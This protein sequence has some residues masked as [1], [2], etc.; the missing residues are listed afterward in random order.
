MPFV[1]STKLD[2]FSNKTQFLSPPVTPKQI[3]ESSFHTNRQTEEYCWDSTSTEASSSPSSSSL[4]YSPNISDNC[5]QMRKKSAGSINIMFT[6]IPPYRR[7]QR[8]IQSLPTST[9]GTFRMPTFVDTV[10]NKKLRKRAK[11][12]KT[13]RNS[14][15]CLATNDCKIEDPTSPLP[16]VGSVAPDQIEDHSD[17]NAE[18]EQEQ[19]IKKAKR[20]AAFVYDNLSA[21]WDQSAVFINSEEWIPKL[22]VFDRRPMVRISWK[23]KEFIVVMMMMINIY[24]YRIST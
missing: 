16:I 20:N 8:P 2:H 12:D 1:N 11:H 14:L 6:A 3:V 4:Y 9:K 13:E 15:L 5:I 7:K 10:S 22:D 17:N 24:Y 21:D 19:I 23:G 18:D